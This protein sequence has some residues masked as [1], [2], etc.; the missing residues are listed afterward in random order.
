MISN[1]H[2]NIFHI[3]QHRYVDIKS[4]IGIYFKFKAR[5]LLQCE[6]KQRVNCGFKLLFITFLNY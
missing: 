2:D 1:Y 3:S 6:R 5:F 4:Q